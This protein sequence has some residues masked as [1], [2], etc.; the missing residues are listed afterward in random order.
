MSHVADVLL[1]TPI[2]EAG[3]AEVQTWL[4]DNKW[5]ELVEIGQEAGGNK[6]MQVEVWAAGINYFN[7]QG[8]VAACQSVKW[9]RPA[10]VQLLIKNENDDVLTL[11]F[12]ASTDASLPRERD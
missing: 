2:S 5:P 4:R 10:W 11:R 3:V 7:I 1:F 6:C 8:F 9:E 12:G